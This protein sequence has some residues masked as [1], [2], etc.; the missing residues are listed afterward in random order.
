MPL[1]EKEQRFLRQI[2]TVQNPSAAQQQTLKTIQEKQAKEDRFIRQYNEIKQSGGQTSAAQDST[3][4]LLTGSTYK[5]PTTPSTPKPTTVS[6]PKTTTPSPTVVQK[7]SQSVGTAV[8]PTNPMKTYTYGNVSMQFANDKEERAYRAAN[9]YAEYTKAKEMKFLQDIDN[10]LKNNQGVSQTQLDQFNQLA[11]KWNYTPTYN[12]PP[13]LE[14]P[15]PFE[16]PRWNAISYDDAVKQAQDQLDPLYQRALENIKAQKYQN[17]LNASEMASNRGL[18]HSGLAADQ[19]TKIAIA[20]QGQMADAEA[21]RASETAKLAQAL[22]E[23]DFDQA[24]QLR[25]QALQEYLANANTNLNYNQAAYGQYA[26]QRDYQAGRDDAMWQRQMTEKQYQSS[27]DDEMRRRAEWE[28]E[29]KWNRLIQSAGLTGEFQGTPTL[30]ALQFALQRQV[31]LGNLSLAQAAQALDEAKFL[32]G[33]KQDAIQNNFKQQELN[34]NQQQLD[35]QKQEIELKKQPQPEDLK[36][37]TELLNRIYL[38]K[39][40]NGSYKV[41][42][43]QVLFDAIVG[44]GLSDADTDKLVNLYG[45]Q[46]YKEQLMKSLGK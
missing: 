44:L 11:K 12:Q 26:D 32:Y 27:R 13:K 33:Q 36:K 30:E 16:A 14:S 23:R 5:P 43:P 35:L 6:A 34:L 41:T 29:Q 19:M 39:T 42:N 2:Q 45:L 3:Y 40:D 4:K 25:Q 17:E 22:M 10:M 46:K 15:E 8:R 24:M 1:T 9:P 20:S 28:S 38:K 31:Q 37:Y 7:P 18:S 21:Q